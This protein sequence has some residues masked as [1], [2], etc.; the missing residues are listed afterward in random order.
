MSDTFQQFGIDW[1]QFLLQMLVFIVALSLA[2]RATRAAVRAY[3]GIELPLWILFVWL[4]PVAGP[5]VTLFAVRA[6]RAHP[7]P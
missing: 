3:R 5:L 2:V 1:P 7:V 4:F 6:R